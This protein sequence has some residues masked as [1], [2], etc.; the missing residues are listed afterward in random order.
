MKLNKKHKAV[1]YGKE[2]FSFV[3][4]KKYGLKNYKGKTILKNKYGYLTASLNCSYS[5]AGENYRTDD[6]ASSIYRNLQLIDSK[7]KLIASQFDSNEF[8]LK[9]SHDKSEGLLIFQLDGKSKYSAKTGLA[10]KCGN[11]LLEPIYTKGSLIP[12]YHYI[13]ATF[14]GK[15]YLFSMDGKAFPT[16]KYDNLEFEFKSTNVVFT[17]D[18][19]QGVVDGNTLKILSEAHYETFTPIKQTKYGVVGYSTLVDGKYGLLDPNM[20]VLAKNESDTEIEIMLG[21]NIAKYKSNGQILVIDIPSKAQFAL[22]YENIETAFG[23]TSSDYV[24]TVN[25]ERRGLFSLKE[26]K[27]ILTPQFDNVSSPSCDKCHIIVTQGK[28][29]YLYNHAGKKLVD[30]G[31]KDLRWDGKEYYKY[32]EGKGKEKGKVT[33]DGEVIIQKF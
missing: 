13:A 7:G 24:V 10:D 20:E 23:K 1:N 12:S 29:K 14:D 31:F 18:G 6:M 3:K 22:D 8:Y 16:E 30:R 32:S 15:K 17:K 21:G 2:F 11:I 27:E 25:D 4:K 9:G 19:K 5:V 28:L 26:G 33:L